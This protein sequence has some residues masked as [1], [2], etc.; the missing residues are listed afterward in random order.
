MLVHARKYRTEDKLKIHTNYFKHNPEKAAI[1]DDMYDTSS[2][3]MQRVFVLNN[4]YLHK[5]HKS[6][7]ECET[8]NK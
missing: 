5:V 7:Y 6:R 8:I 3:T 4:C 2:S 1:T